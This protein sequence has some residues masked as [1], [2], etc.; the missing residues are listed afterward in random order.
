MK[1]HNNESITR[2]IELIFVKHFEQCLVEYINNTRTQT[3]GFGLE[4]LVHHCC[5]YYLSQPLIMSRRGIEWTQVLGTM[6]PQSGW[7]RT[8]HMSPR[9]CSIKERVQPKILQTGA[10]GK[11]L[12]FK[13]QY[14][15]VSLRYS[16]SSSLITGMQ[17]NLL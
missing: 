8:G 6:Y 13:N 9:Q 15:P 12:L 16:R 5:L 7:G 1:I 2:V 10:L 11:L 4:S 3:Q 14:L 17:G